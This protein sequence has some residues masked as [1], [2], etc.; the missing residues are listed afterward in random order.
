MRIATNIPALNTAIT[1]KHTDSN[2]ANAMQKL[3]TGSQIS[4]AKYDSAGLAIANKLSV[5]ISGLN[6]ASQNSMD[7]ISVVQTA[8]GALSSV[9]NMIQ[10]MRELAI[11]AANGVLTLDDKEKIQTEVNQLVEEIDST[12]D[13]TEFNRIKLLNGEA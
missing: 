11:Q 5:Q 3:T 12:A 8:D 4:S 7:G 10:R 2:I 9:T 13:K 6:Q 1:L